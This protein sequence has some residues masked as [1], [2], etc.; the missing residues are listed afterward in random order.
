MISFFST[1]VFAFF[2]KNSFIFVD[3]SVMSIISFS[4]RLIRFSNSSFSAWKTR[5]SALYLAFSESRSLFIRSFSKG[6]FRLSPPWFSTFS[7]RVGSWFLVKFFLISLTIS[8][9]EKFLLLWILICSK[10]PEEAV[11]N[12][13]WWLFPR[14]VYGSNSTFKASTHRLKNFSGSPYWETMSFIVSMIFS[15]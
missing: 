2:L 15:F 14:V 13:S 4:C 3:P 1:S 11:S 7:N 6:F 10:I 5:N 9:R 8:G 12:W